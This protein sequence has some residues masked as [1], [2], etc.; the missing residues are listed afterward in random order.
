MIVEGDVLEA[1]EQFRLHINEFSVG[2][3]TA[4]RSVGDAA[5]G[6]HVQALVF[7]GRTEMLQAGRNRIVLRNDGVTLTVLQLFVSV[8]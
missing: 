1:L 6:K 7:P 5:S 2:K 8:E 3:A 4:I